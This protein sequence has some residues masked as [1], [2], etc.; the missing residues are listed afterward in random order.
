[1]KFLEYIKLRYRAG[2]YKYRND[3]GG[4]AY[5]NSAISEGQTVF[6][7]GS[8][9]AAYIYFMR[10]KAGNKGNINAFEPQENLY[11]YIRRIKKLFAWNNVKVEQLALSDSAGEATLFIPVNKEGKSSSPGATIVKNKFHPTQVTSENVSTETLDRY[12]KHNMLCPDF[13]KIDVEGNEL[14]VLKGG[15]DTLKNCKPKILVEIEARHVGQGLV[16]ET[17]NFLESLGYTGYLLHGMEQI[18]LSEF[19][20]DKYQ[21]VDDRKNYSNNFAFEHKK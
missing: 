4:I 12:C 19:S 11:K 14:K 9:K 10:I 20:F 21:N 13:L 3:R 6:D 1:M 17:F 7:I 15:I 2:R 5:I 16:L 18:P 8:H